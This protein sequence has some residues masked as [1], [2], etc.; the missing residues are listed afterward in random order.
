ML[1]ARSVFEAAT[2]AFRVAS[3]NTGWASHRAMPA[4]RFL[5]I[6]EMTI[7]DWLFE[8]EVVTVT[9]SSWSCRVS[10]SASRLPAPE[11]RSTSSARR[12]LVV[13]RP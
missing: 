10:C 4:S 2:R 7:A 13:G 9:P 12:E 11:T 1:F 8:H 3:S 5:S 6:P